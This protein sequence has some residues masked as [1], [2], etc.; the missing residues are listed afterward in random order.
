MPGAGRK[1]LRTSTYILKDDLSKTYLVEEEA[2]STRRALDKLNWF[3]I[4]LNAEK[5]GS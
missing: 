5:Y 4:I 2:T 1:M 3:S